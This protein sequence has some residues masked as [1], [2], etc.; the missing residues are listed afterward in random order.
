MKQLK[1]WMSVGTI[2]L[3][4]CTSG[5]KNTNTTQGNSQ[6]RVKVQKLETG[7]GSTASSY[8]GT[9]EESAMIPLSFLITGSIEKVLVDE[10]QSVSKGQLLAVL[11]SESYQNAYQISLSKEKQA[12]DA[13][14][15]L[16][17]VYKK[18]SLPEVKYIEIVTGLDQARSFARMSEKNLRDS[19]LYA[20]T[21]G[22]IGKRMIEPGMSIVPGNP[23]FQLVKIEKV[24][25][26]IPVPE[27]EIVGIRKGQKAQV[28][29]SA[30]GDQSFEG[31]VTEIGVLSNLFSH[32]YSV[33]VELDNPQGSLKPGM[34][35]E[36]TINNPT[37]TNRIIVPLSAVQ[38]T[39]NG[40][41]Y[42]FIAGNGTV[43]KRTVQTGALVN[44]GVVIKNGLSVG[45]LLIIEGYQKI[46]QNSSI[47]IIR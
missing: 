5:P 45:D 6:V 12:Q 37:M 32:T 44:T 24:K 3:A 47:Q 31:E 19:K 40:M 9:I 33:K 28:R 8:I 42:V 46:D 4:G 26:S 15:R 1:I 25:V 22:M 36:A 29:V 2:V 13:F 10:G 34:V 20:P 21:S 41:K 39:G 43:T 16:D 35:C 11:N 38:Q 23:V 7:S 18:G 30:I 27:N 14:N 17:S